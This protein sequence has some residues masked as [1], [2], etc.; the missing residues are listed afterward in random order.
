M[1]AMLLQKE[2][3]KNVEVTLPTYTSVGVYTYNISQ[4]AGTTAGVTY[5]AVPVVMKVTVLNQDGGVGVSTVSFTKNGTKL[6]DAAAFTNIYTAN[7]LSVKKTVSGDLGD[8]SKYFDFEV[9]MTGS[10]RQTVRSILCGYR[11]F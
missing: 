9:T 11:R 7:T 8:K 6:D 4:T 2:N 1:R 10:G 3:K 5:D